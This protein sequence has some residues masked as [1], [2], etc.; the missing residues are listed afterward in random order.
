MGA[1]AGPHTLQRQRQAACDGNRGAKM[2]NNVTNERGLLGQFSQSTYITLGDPYIKKGTMLSRYKKKQ[3]LTMPA[4]KGRTK[5]TMFGKAFPFLADGDKYNDKTSYLKTQPRETRKK[6]FLS[7]DAFRV[8]EFSSTLRMNQYRWGLG[9]E[10]ALNKMHLEANKK[11]DEAKKKERAST[12]PGSSREVAKTK[13]LGKIDK[14][15]E[16]PYFLYDIGK[17]KCVTAFDQKLSRE[18]WYQTNRNADA[19][20]NLGDWL[21]SSYEIGNEMVQQHDLAKPTYAS[22][23]II[24]STFYRV[25]NLKANSGW[26]SLPST[27]H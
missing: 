15:L 8:D 14:N 5:D 7:S 24:R 17:G 1:S 6:G 2:N 12:A 16:T 10:A 26:A 20:R 13:E 21:P 11:R 27:A 23:P 25:G 4:K 19:P 9:R 22:I 18:N 3:F